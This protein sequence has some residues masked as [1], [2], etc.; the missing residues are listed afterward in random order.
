MSDAPP[1]QQTQQPAPPRQQQ[2]Q[3]A[4]LSHDQVKQSFRAMQKVLEGASSSEILSLS[5]DISVAKLIV[6]QFLEDR[7]VIIP[8]DMIREAPPEQP[9]RAERRGAEA[10][11]R[12]KKKVSKKKTSAKR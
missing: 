6:Q 7:L 10:A 1:E 3:Q 12:S 9:N 4:Q 5:G 2:Q 8:K 11:A